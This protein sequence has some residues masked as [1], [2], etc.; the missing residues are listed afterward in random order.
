M[1]P[2]VSVL[3]PVYNGESHVSTAIDSILA[4]TFTNFEFLVIDDGSTDS[5]AAIARAYDDPRLRFVENQRNLGIAATLNRGLGLARGDFIA[6]MDADDISHPLRLEKQVA[7]L[8]RHFDVGVLGTA[9]QY[10]DESGNPGLVWSPPLEHTLL[11]W[12]LCFHCPL[13]H[14]SVIVRKEILSEVGGYAEVRY[15]EDYEL[16][17]RIAAMTRMASLSQPLVSLRRRS[18]SITTQ[19]H[20]DHHCQVVKISQEIMSEML[21]YPLP[22]QLAKNVVYMST[23]SADDSFLSA[24]VVQM[25]FRV[26][27]ERHIP[28]R[29][30]QRE[31]ADDASARIFH[32]AYH[33]YGIR[34]QRYLPVLRWAWQIA[35]TSTARTVLKFAGRKSRHLLGLRSRR[36]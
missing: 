29:Y 32:W 9:C 26:F 15:A 20:D 16:W 8:E 34:D 19:Y 33:L 23:E 27:I 10:I 17:R 7:Y 31:I 6:R 13:P 30:E 18:T 4:Q 28:S 22:L 2:K 24:Q 25:L 21:G 36:N 3:M 1:I 35:P 11:N 14:P 5:T 12:Q